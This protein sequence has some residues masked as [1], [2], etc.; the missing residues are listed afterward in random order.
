M[1]ITKRLTLSIIGIVVLLGASLFAWQRGQASQKYVQ[2]T[3][4]TFFF[5]GYGSSLNAEKHMT[6]A[7]KRAGVTNTVVWADVDETGHVTF[8]G[9]IKKGAINPIIQVNYQN[10]R[11]TNYHTDGQWA[12]NVVSQAKAKWNF[13]KMNLV[14]HSMGNMDIMYMLLDHANS[15]KLPQLNKQVDLA[16]HFNGLKG[17]ATADANLDANGKPQTTNQFYQELLQLRQT[18]PQNAQVMNIYGNLN[19]GSNGDGSVPNNSS[20]SLRYLVADRAKSYTEHEITGRGG[21]HSKLHSNAE[22]DHLLIDFLWKR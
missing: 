16:G 1:K 3:T 20:K 9:D 17:Q 15:D 19:D 18:Y 4:P 5:H 2:S 6:N 14:G 13:K 8:H 7:A 11:Q 12:F 21:Q 10:P 22:V